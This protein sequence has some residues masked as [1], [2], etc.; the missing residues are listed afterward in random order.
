MHGFG[1]LEQTTVDS[2]FV[3]DILL[4]HAI[5]V[6]IQM[7]S[8]LNSILRGW[9]DSPAAARPLNTLPRR[10]FRGVPHRAHGKVGSG[11]YPGSGFCHYWKSAFFF[12]F[13]PPWKP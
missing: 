13:A 11:F 7:E 9:I 6:K 4:R 1:P 12:F 8:L 10:F 5:I 2:A 3:R